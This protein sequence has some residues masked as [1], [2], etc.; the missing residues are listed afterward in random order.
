VGARSITVQDFE[1]NCICM[2]EYEL[3]GRS[4]NMELMLCYLAQAY[5]ERNHDLLT[6]L[7]VEGNARVPLA[8]PAI[9][10]QHVILRYPRICSPGAWSQGLYAST[11][12]EL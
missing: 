3:A 10:I 11:S 8:F 6:F 12:D 4:T 5:M 1:H 9:A 7:D 2:T